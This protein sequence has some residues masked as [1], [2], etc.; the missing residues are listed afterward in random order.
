V[1]FQRHAFISY[2]HIDN[3]PLPTESSGWVTLFHA[4]LQ[5][6][7]AGR[8]G[9]RADIWRD[10]RLRGNDLFA[11]EIVAN[12]EQTAVLVS[13][14]SPRYLKSDWCRRE[15][16]EF[17]QTAER[18]GGL[19]VDNKCRVF[20]VF[21]FPLDEA[22]DDAL[23]ATLQQVLGYQFYETDEDQTTTRELAPSYGDK[24]KQDFMRRVAKLAFDI[25]QLLGKLECHAE[26]EA[27]AAPSPAGRPV[28]YLASCGHDRREQREMLELELDRMG[29]DVL[30]DRQ[31][32]TGEA[33]FVAEVE[34]LLAR[35]RV[36]IHLIGSSYGMVPDGPTDK[37][38]AVLQNELAVQR[39]RAGALARLVWLPQGTASSHPLQAA[40]IEALHQEAEAQFG[41][42]LITG[43]F[44]TLKAAVHALLDKLQQPAPVAPEPATPGRR[45]LHLLCSERDRKE[46]VAL[47]RQL[48]LTV[49]VSLPVFTGDAGAVREANQALLMACDQVLLY[50]GEG[51]EAWKFHQQNEL[52]RIRALRGGTPLPPEHVYLAAPNSDDKDIL[53]ELGEPRLIDGRGGVPAAID[54]AP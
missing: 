9:G 23:P 37:S 39:C 19:V 13:V 49:D 15:I 35:S 54:L 38:V 30:P 33:E 27:A 51:D 52:R 29:Y 46:S 42:D 32:P 34:R 2:A 16:S 31:L 8:L 4:A 7:L 5:Q 41:A 36:A 12:F 20:K 40:F 3:E 14:L 47:V 17:C 44:E 53:V 43:E 50:Y 28:V 25:R 22:D 18:N 11:D 45:Q 21:K 24:S 48:R 6:M 26:T 10:E 1:S